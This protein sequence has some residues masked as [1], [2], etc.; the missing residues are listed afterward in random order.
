MLIRWI[1]SNMAPFHLQSDF[2]RQHLTLNPFIAHNGGWMV[3]VA[4]AAPLADWLNLVEVPCSKTQLQR[5]GGIWTANLSVSDPTPP[6]SRHLHSL[7]RASLPPPPCSSSWENIFSKSSE[8]ISSQEL[9]CCRRVV[10]LC[11]DC[12]LV[13]Y[14]FVSESRGSLSGLSPEWDDT[15]WGFVVS[16]WLFVGVW[17][18]FF[19][20]SSWNPPFI[21]PASG[22]GRLPSSAL[23]L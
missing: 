13:V 18:L 6:H 21:Q 14:K 10:Q 12:L 3:C 15:R 19:W 17:G 11:R 22:S 4:T 23:I 20:H 9:Q 2:L 7:S 1:V 16:F 5:W 8:V